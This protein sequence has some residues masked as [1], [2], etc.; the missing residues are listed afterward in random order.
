MSLTPDEIGRDPVIMAADSVAKA[1]EDL[2][3]QVTRRTLN[4][5]AAPA[6]AL[7]PLASAADPPG[8]VFYAGI[9]PPFGHPVEVRAA[10]IDAGHGEVPYVFWDWVSIDPEFITD[11]G[12]GAVGAWATHASFAPPRSAFVDRYRAAYGRE[13]GEYEAAGYACLEVILAALRDLA[14]EGA[15]TETIREAL[16]AEAVD[17]AKRYE[18]VLGTI[19]FDANGDSL[20]QFAQVF[21]ADPEGAGGQPEWVLVNSQD[22]GP[23]P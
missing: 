21:R 2:G 14:K 17:P 5:G 22:Y 9:G 4:P 23:A 20:Q 15:S 11:L 3:G 8:A 12:T 10:M 6:T 13:P 16:R 18:T 7:E 1:F 19:G